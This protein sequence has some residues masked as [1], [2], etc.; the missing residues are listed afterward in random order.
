[1]KKILSLFSAVAILGIST[2]AAAADVIKIGHLAALTGPTSDV[3][4]S[5]A[6]GVRA[7]ADYINSKGGVNGK[8]IEVL[9]RDYAYDKKTAVTLYRS[10]VADGIIALQGWG[11]ADTEALK[12]QVNVDKIPDLSASY[13]ANLT[14]PADA[15]YNFFIAADYTTQLRGALK[16]AK[17]NWKESRKPRVA[18]VYPNHPYGIAPI[19]G[20]K[21]YAEEIGFEILTDENVALNAQEATT[22]ILS[23]KNGAP[24]F[25]WIGGTTASTS[26]ILKGAKQNGLKTQF[27]I[28]IWGND[29]SLP[30]R[31]EGAEEGVWGLHA[32]SAYEDDAPGMKAI[33]EVTKGV[34]Q[35]I[36][37][38]RGWVSM[39]VM[40]EA[41]KI[42]DKAGK[43]SGEGIKEALETLKNF[44]TG[45]LTAPVTFTATDHRPNMSVKIFTFKSGQLKKVASVELERRADWLGL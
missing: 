18:F 35:T 28:N 24:D 25:V 9:T 17:D 8:K 3:G 27:I 29:E 14:N 13:S 4:T 45:G 22:Q 26:V 23:L 2:F 43:L 20:A 34:P 41:L 33:K 39:M 30:K 37:Y 42:A 5:Y 16:Y 40:T 12:D 15:P 21:A 11:T 7:Y 36:H 1:M 10:L 44:D 32:N 6:E 38:I 31:A 19:K